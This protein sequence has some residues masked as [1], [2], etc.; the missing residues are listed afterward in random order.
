MGPNVYRVAVV[1]GKFIKPGPKISDAAIDGPYYYDGFPESWVSIPGT[2]ADPM[3]IAGTSYPAAKDHLW[4]GKNEA[5][6]HNMAAG[7][8]KK[9]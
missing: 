4:I 1:G 8:W 3:T 5:A 2:Q 7:I 6:A 9:K